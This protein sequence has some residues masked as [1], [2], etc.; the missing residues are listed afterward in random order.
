MKFILLTSPALVG[1]TETLGFKT[2]VFESKN[3]TEVSRTPI[4]DKARKCRVFLQW[5][6]EMKLHSIL[7]LN[8][9]ESEKTGSSIVS[10]I[11]ICW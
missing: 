1:G 6:Y 9:Q 10:G 3:G 4:K 7:M 5:L 2:D 11:S 8:G